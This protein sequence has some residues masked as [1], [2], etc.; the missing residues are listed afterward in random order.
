MPSGAVLK[1]GHTPFGISKALYRAFLLE[2]KGVPI[3]SKAELNEVFKNMF[4]FVSTSKEFEKALEDCFKRCTYNNLKVEESSFEPI[5][6]REDYVPVCIA[7]A[8]ENITPFTKSLFAE[9][10]KLLALLPKDPA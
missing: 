6:T 9:F 10:E 3:S 1:I 8:K 7:V 4:C 5:E 2:M